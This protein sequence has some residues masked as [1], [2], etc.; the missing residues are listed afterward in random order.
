MAGDGNAVADDRWMR[1]VLLS[2]S[3]LFGVSM[4]VREIDR[5]DDDDG[6]GDDDDDGGERVMSARTT[7]KENDFSPSAAPPSPPKPPLSPRAGVS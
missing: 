7:R 2:S 5:D 3:L 1:M 6:D 4:L